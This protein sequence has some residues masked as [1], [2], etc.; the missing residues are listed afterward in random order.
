MKRCCNTLIRKAAVIV[1]FL[2]WISNHWHNVQLWEDKQ[3]ARS[4]D[5]HTWLKCSTTVGTKSMSLHLSLDGICLHEKI[6]VWLIIRHFIT[7]LV[8]LVSPRATGNHCSAVNLVLSAL[9]SFT[10]DTVK[11]AVLETEN[12]LCHTGF[13]LI[14]MEVLPSPKMQK[15]PSSTYL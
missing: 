4:K 15:I 3:D 2:I 13:K 10:H 12:Y 5:T 7:C 6:T 1:L 8:K 11:G 14:M 9:K